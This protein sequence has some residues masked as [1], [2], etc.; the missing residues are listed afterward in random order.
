MENPISFAKKTLNI[1][2][3]NNRFVLKLFGEMNH[4][5]ITIEKDEILTIS[6]MREEHFE[7][8]GQITKCKEYLILCTFSLILYRG[9]KKDV[10][11]LFILSNPLYH[12]KSQSR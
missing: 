11:V 12:F 1:N 3:K 2:Q 8:K 10:N 4:N 9:L 7:K 6:K 5:Y